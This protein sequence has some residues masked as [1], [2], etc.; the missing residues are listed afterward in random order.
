MEIPPR[1]E[2]RRFP[3]KFGGNESFL[4]LAGYVE[5][6]EREVGIFSVSRILQESKSAFQQSLS[7]K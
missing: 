1:A 5:E 6:G 2:R 7:I 3:W 4:C